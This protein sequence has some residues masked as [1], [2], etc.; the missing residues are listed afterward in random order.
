[1]YCG[2]LVC[3][4]YMSVAKIDI[5]SWNRQCA[6]GSNR[7]MNCAVI[8]IGG[9]TDNLIK[10]L[11][12]SPFSCV[13]YEQD[14]ILRCRGTDLG[15]LICPECVMKQAEGGAVVSELGERGPEDAVT[16]HGV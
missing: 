4:N 16:A 13:T 8:D 7:D 3:H 12:K 15:S 5:W 10:G 2:H 1:M 14:G 9:P 6:R 11:F